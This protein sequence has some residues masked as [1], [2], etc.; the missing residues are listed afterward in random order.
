MPVARPSQRA[1]ALE[2]AHWVAAVFGSA[3]ACNLQPAA[4]ARLYVFG[5]LSGYIPIGCHTVFISWKSKMAYGDCERVASSQPIF[6]PL[7]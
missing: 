4:G 1:G 3:T 5:K 6:A 7:K 2:C